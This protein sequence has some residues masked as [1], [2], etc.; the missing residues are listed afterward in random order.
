M[1]EHQGL[2]FDMT[3]DGTLIFYSIGL[4]CVHDIWDPR[5]NE[6]LEWEVARAKFS[7]YLL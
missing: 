3:M 1:M 6:F 5:R 4:R 2:Y 7:L